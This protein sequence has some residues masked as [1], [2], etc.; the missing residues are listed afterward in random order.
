MAQELANLV[1]GISPDEIMKMRQDEQILLVEGKTIR[2]KQA[3]YYSDQAFVA[4]A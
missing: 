4:K 2:C 3:R 1:G